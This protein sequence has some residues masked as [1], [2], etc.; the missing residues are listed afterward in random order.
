MKLIG[1]SCSPQKGKTTYYTLEKCFD[2]LKTVYSKMETEI[3]DLGGMNISGCRDCG[4]CKNELNCKI[5]DDFIKLIPKLSTPDIKGIIIATPVYLGSMTSL[6]KAFLERTVMFRRNGF[7]FRNMVGGVIA[8]GAVRNGGQ[9]LTIQSVQAGMLCHDMIIVS[10]GNNTSH[11]GGTVWSKIEGGIEK[12]EFGIKT[13][14]NLVKRAA[15]LI[16]KLN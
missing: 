12:D 16:L 11:F 15:E 2:Y 3:I 7:L 4:H 5:N 6:C 9:E 14:C 8:V 13:A 10:D 1:I